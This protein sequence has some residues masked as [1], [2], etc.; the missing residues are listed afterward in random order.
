MIIDMKMFVDPLPLAMLPTQRQTVARAGSVPEARSNNEQIARSLF[1]LPS[2]VPLSAFIAVI[3]PKLQDDISERVN[4]LRFAKLAP[5]FSNRA[6]P[7]SRRFVSHLGH[8]ALAF[9]ASDPPTSGRMGELRDNFPERHDVISRVAVYRI[10]GLPSS[11]ILSTLRSHTACASCHLSFQAMR[12]AFASAGANM[13][14]DAWAVAFADHLARCGGDAS[15]HT[16][17][18]WLVTALAE[19]RFVAQ[20]GLASR[21]PQFPRC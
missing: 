10:F 2:L 16:A 9:S 11:R 6:P 18:Y 21:F 17:H 5:T 1:G 4:L 8:G 7:E 12:G 20:S 13:S 3:F 14:D 15:V 19:I